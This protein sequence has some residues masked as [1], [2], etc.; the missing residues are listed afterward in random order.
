MQ[1]T[2]YICGRS[3]PQRKP[4]IYC[5]D[6]DHPQD[7]DDML[8]GRGRGEVRKCTDEGGKVGGDGKSQ[9]SSGK[10]GREGGG[11][12]EG[13]REGKGGGLAGECVDG[14]VTL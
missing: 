11:G 3:L 8:R 10:R 6:G 1:G 12:K 7:A 13:E 5:V 14:P 2:P 4:C 9:L